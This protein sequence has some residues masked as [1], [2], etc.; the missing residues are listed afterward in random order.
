[1]TYYLHTI[2]DY[3]AGYDG[4]QICYADNLGRA[5]VLCTSLRQIRMEQRLSKRN[6]LRDEFTV[7]DVQYGYKRVSVKAKGGR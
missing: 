1:M 5:V 4:Y 6:R 7:S 3:P 2:N